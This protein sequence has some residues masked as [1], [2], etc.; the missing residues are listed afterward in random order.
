MHM[1]DGSLTTRQNITGESAKVSNRN[2]WLLT[3]Y[4]GPQVLY[5][6]YCT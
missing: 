4:C 5:M 2:L 1:D 6:W 3:C